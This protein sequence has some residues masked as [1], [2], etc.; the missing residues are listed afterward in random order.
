MLYNIKKKLFRKGNPAM[1]NPDR[2]R[3]CGALLLSSMLQEGS[4]ELLRQ[5]PE[6]PAILLFQRGYG[7]PTFPGHWGGPGGLFEAGVDADE[8]AAAERE[9]FEETNIIFIPETPA[10]YKGVMPDRDL[11]YHIG[12][13]SIGKSGIRYNDNEV[14]G[15]GWFTGEQAQKLDLSFHYQTAIEKLIGRGML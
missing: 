10:F 6:D 1:E 5:L 14:I 7:A 12:K 3:G 2:K 13:W 15:H 8:A 11:I 4:S 9:T